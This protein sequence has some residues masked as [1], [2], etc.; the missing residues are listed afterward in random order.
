MGD[1]RPRMVL[2]FPGL[3]SYVD[4]GDILLRGRKLE[5]GLCVCVCVFG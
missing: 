4:D 3:S 1:E 5:Y 2:S